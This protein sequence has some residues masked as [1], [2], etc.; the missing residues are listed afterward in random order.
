MQQQALPCRCPDGPDGVRTVERGPRHRGAPPGPRAA[1]PTAPGVR[2]PRRHGDVGRRGWRRLAVPGPGPRPCGRS[3]PH[4]TTASTCGASSTG[5]GST[6]TSGCAGFDVQLACS[7]ATGRRSRA[8]RWQHSGP[9]PLSH[10]ARATS[11]SGC[12]EPTGNRS[13][14]LWKGSWEALG[15]TDAAR[16]TDLAAAAEAAGR[17]AAS[18]VEDRDAGGL[19]P[20]PAVG[21]A[22]RGARRAEARRRLHRDQPPHPRLRRT[23]LAS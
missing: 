11:G 19:G 7:T 10:R 2:A 17:H 22:D 18:F 20:A 15:V 12:Q 4:S 5:P 9:R 23:S 16:P 8:P 3:R 14:W 6:T 1:G 21:S 13:I